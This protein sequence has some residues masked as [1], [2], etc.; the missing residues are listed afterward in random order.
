MA[1]VETGSITFS[2]TGN[3]IVTLADASLQI[4]KI[5]ICVSDSTTVASFGYSDGTVNFTGGTAYGDEDDTKTITHYRNVSGTKTK[6][7]EGLI[8]GTGFSSAGEFTINIS[9]LS[10]PTQIKFTVYGV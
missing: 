1:K 9:T 8:S 2:S 4:Q 6:I 3:K 5:V 10:T 7:I